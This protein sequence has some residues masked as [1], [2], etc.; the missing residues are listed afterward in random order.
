MYDNPHF[1]SLTG[2]GPDHK[3]SGS[4]QVRTYPINDV[5]SRFDESIKVIDFMSI[6]VEGMELDILE[7]MDF[8]KYRP[9]LLII[10]NHKSGI[11]ANGLDQ[12]I[13][14]KGYRI[15]AIGLN[16]TFYLSDSIT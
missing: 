13:T 10:E 12:F 14:D 8:D 1:N 11:E 7:T 15:R 4:Y 5:L 6:D 3:Y 2:N 16:S 9:N